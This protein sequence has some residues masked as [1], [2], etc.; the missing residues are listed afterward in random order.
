MPSFWSTADVK[1]RPL[2]CLLHEESAKNVALLQ[3]SAALSLFNL[4]ATFSRYSHF[5]LTLQH[6]SSK[7]AITGMLCLRKKR[8]KYNNR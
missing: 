4:S 5:P 6:I 1:P 8:P 7:E 3:H 2:W